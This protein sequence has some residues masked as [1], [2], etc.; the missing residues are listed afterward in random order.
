MCMV[1]SESDSNEGIKLGIGFGILAAFLIA[2]IIITG[3]LLLALF[4]RRKGKQ[5]ISS[6]IALQYQTLL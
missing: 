3:I 6:A 2:V 1:G 5:T 4:L